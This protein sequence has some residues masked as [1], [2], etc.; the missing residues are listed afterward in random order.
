MFAGGAV[1]GAVLGS[2]LVGTGRLWVLPARTATG[3]AAQESVE[4]A[5]RATARTQPGASATVWLFTIASGVLV[6]NL[7]IRHFRRFEPGGPGE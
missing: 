3:R 6:A 5:A 4:H 1:W 2:A 7:G